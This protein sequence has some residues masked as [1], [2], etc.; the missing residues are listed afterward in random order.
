MGIFNIDFNFYI[1]FNL[2][3]IEIFVN[4]KLDRTFLQRL[5]NY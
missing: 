4:S 3:C 5:I 2:R 1:Y